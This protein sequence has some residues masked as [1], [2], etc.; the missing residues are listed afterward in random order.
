MYYDSY[1]RFVAR[2]TLHVKTL[3]GRSAECRVRPGSTV[4]QLKLEIERLHSIPVQ[5][6]RLFYLGKE[7][8]AP[9]KSLSILGVKHEATIYIVFK[10]PS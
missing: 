1:F 5:Q 2:V 9:T 4:E 3:M 10:L 8:L 6:Q 7:L